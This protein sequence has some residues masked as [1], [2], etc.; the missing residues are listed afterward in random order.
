LAGMCVG[1]VPKNLCTPWRD[2]ESNGNE[3]RRQQHQH[4]HDVGR[5]DPHIH[6]KPEWSASWGEGERNSP[7]RKKTGL[8]GL[9]VI[10]MTR[11]ADAD[12]GMGG[13]GEK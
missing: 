4:Q 9:M 2:R 10:V 11:Y 7:S 6:E 12:S 1:G 8:I 13:D 3:H 5:R